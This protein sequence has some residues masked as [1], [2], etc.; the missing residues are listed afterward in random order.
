M[1]NPGQHDW[2][3]VRTAFNGV[4]VM[5]WREADAAVIREGP[6]NV[7]L[8]ELT[9]PQELYKEIV[10]KSGRSSGLRIC[11][12]QRSVALSRV[13]AF[14]TGQ[15]RPGVRVSQSFLRP[16]FFYSFSVPFSRLG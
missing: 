6:L 9:G 8:H 3:R 7:P 13:H 4:E 14:N 2:V 5:E 12:C 1:E 10:V 16:A 11:D 15:T